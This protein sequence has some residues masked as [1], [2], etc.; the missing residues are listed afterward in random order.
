MIE[1]IKDEIQSFEGKTI[2]FRYNGSRNQTEEFEG[3]I[4]K[5]YKCLF[6]IESRNFSKTFTY[7]DI[8][9]GVLE[10]NI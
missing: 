4:T 2:K 3:I 9:T 5:C 8:L 6:L 7:S 1:K 10:V